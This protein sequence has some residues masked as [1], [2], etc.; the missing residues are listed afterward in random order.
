[1]GQTACVGVFIRRGGANFSSDAG[2]YLRPQVRAGV[3][4]VVRSLEMAE[5]LTMRSGFSCSRNSIHQLGI[6]PVLLYASC[7]KHILYSTSRSAYSVDPRT[8][9][10]ACC[11]YHTQKKIHSLAFGW[12]LA[13]NR[14]VCGSLSWQD[15]LMG[16][17][18]V[19]T[20]SLQRCSINTRN[21]TSSV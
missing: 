12:R 18:Y 20:A 5:S 3:D 17:S 7:P 9:Q 14:Y 10:T 2:S 1:M 6:V 4:Y 11:K 21:E 13:P 8:T 19:C 15:L 16:Y